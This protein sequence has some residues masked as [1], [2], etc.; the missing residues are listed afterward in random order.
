MR[1]GTGLRSLAFFPEGNGNYWMIL[2]L[3]VAQFIDLELFTGNCPEDH[4]KKIGNRRVGGCRDR[5][6]G[7]GTVTVIPLSGCGVGE[8][9]P[10]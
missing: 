9:G 4:R 3:E 6:M 8:D 1:Q 5:M 2:R 7:L 10:G